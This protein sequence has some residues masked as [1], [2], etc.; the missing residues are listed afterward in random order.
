[1]T[2]LPFALSFVN[3]GEIDSRAI[4]ILGVNAKEGPHP[5]GHFGTGLKYAIAQILANGG[6][7]TIWNGLIPMRFETER[8]SIRGQQFD[9]INMTEGENQCP[10]WL[11]GFTT[12]LGKHW[13]PWMIYRELYCNALDEGGSVVEGLVEPKLGHVVIQ[14]R[15]WEALQTAHKNRHDFVLESTPLHRIPDK[16]GEMRLE[17]HAGDGTIFYRGIRVAKYTR[18]AKYNYNLL[19]ELAL[20]EDRTLSISTVDL[21]IS[22]GLLG[23][24]VGPTE[25]ELRAMILDENSMEHYIDWH[26]FDEADQTR[27]DQLERLVKDCPAAVP[28]TVNAYLMR[29]RPKAFKPDLEEVVM[30]P[31]EEASIKRAIEFL[32]SIGLP[33]TRPIRLVE[34]LGSPTLHGLAQNGT[35]WLPRTTL[36]KGTRYVAST[37]LEEELHLVK[38]LGD[39]TRDMQNHLF[40]LIVTLGCELTGDPL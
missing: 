13:Q 8:G 23:S 30:R 19:R 5:I 28:Q 15:N 27:L 35:I 21:E 7:I 6:Q 34:S 16:Q 24:S 26:W 18:T 40:D 38:G 10:P 1:M 2:H 33:I 3:P 25:E 12:D 4:S 20:T 32:A 14:V 36:A 37:I 31:I 9:F 22:M 11:L 29:F 39:C 17:L